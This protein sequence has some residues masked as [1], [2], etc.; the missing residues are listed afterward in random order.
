MDAFGVVVPDCGHRAGVVVG[1]LR[2]GLGRFLVLGSSRKR[3]L[4]A[5]VDFGGFAALC[6]RGGKA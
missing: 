6:D 2:T 5:L 1:L 4:Y 3:I